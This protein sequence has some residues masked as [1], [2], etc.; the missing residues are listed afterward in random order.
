MLPAL[1]VA[2]EHLFCD[3]AER[4]VLPLALD[5]T[6]LAQGVEER[7]VAHV[8]VDMAVLEDGEVVEERMADHDLGGED[9]LDGRLDGFEGRCC[10]Q[11]CAGRGPQAAAWPGP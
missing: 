11:L 10:G 7:R 6:P 1:Y 4:G 3:V 5:A 8:F 2:A 9:G